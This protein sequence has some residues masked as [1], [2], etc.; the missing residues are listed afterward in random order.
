MA[1]TQSKLDAAKACFDFN[2][3]ATEVFITDDLACFFNNNRAVNHASGLVTKDID[4][5]TRSTDA[6]ADPV[7]IATT[8]PG[9]APADPS[10]TRANTPDVAVVA[11]VAAAGAP[12]ADETAAAAPAAESKE[13]TVKHLIEEMVDK[14]EHLFESKEGE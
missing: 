14:V 12:V 2:Q 9:V 1:N 5:Y 3:D 11:P 7:I 4:H 10:S 8:Q 13:D 6:I